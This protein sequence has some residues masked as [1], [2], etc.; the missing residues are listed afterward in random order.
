MN[1]FEVKPAG[2]WA[3]P[4]TI[5]AATSGV[6]VYML[7]SKKSKWESPLVGVGIQRNIQKTL[8]MRSLGI[9]LQDEKCLSLF[10]KMMA[11]KEGE[12]PPKLDDVYMKNRT[13]FAL[14]TCRVLKERNVSRQES[15]AVLDECYYINENGELCDRYLLQ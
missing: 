6:L 5:G 3:I 8:E 7:C 12:V 1:T 2:E 13:E 9:A 14:G 11:F 10:Q 4:A 15:R